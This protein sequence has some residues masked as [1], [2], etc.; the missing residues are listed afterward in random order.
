MLP[1]TA[2]SHEAKLRT[3]RKLNA[4]RKLT[5]KQRNDRKRTSSNCS[6]GVAISDTGTPNRIFHACDRP[7]GPTC[8]DNQ[9][10]CTADTKHYRTPICLRTRH[11]SQKPFS[12]DR[13]TVTGQPARFFD[14]YSLSWSCTY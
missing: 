4:N 1:K 11:S 5:Q 6:C 2:M 9:A 7:I 3:G 10:H 12:V 14:R 13:T 8:T